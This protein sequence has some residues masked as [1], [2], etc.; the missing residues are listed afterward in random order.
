MIL[1]VEVA[2]ACVWLYMHIYDYAEVLCI[3][4]GDFGVLGESGG[5]WTNLLRT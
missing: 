5:S 1:G 2:C 3:F 4:P